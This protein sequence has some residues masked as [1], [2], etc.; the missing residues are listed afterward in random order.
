MGWDSRQF[1]KWG[2]IIQIDTWHIEDH[3]FYMRR[4]HQKNRHARSIL[5]QEVWEGF[6]NSQKLSLLCF[7]I[8]FWS[9]CLRVNPGIGNLQSW[10]KQTGGRVPSL[11]LVF[12]L[13]LNWIVKA[14]FKNIKIGMNKRGH[15]GFTEGAV[16]QWAW[17][18][19][20]N[21]TLSWS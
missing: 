20:T 8:K 2:N 1:P 11:T 3:F 10:R 12:S 9:F 6:T 7:E 18:E 5:L 4:Q 15:L 16:Q 21:G 13:F 14:F 17:L 19:S